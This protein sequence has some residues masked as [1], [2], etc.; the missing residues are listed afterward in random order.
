MIKEFESTVTKAELDAEIQNGPVLL[1][2]FSR[3]CGPCKML[4]FVLKNIDKTM[5][6]KVKF[7]KIP[8]E[9]NKELVT[10]YNVEGYPTIIMLKD[11]KE[12]GRKAGLQQ[13]PV[14]VGLINEAL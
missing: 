2:F 14:I 7:V 11:G 10:E 1:D 8:F 6:E 3:T 12:I 9:D 4:A 13:Q 5:G